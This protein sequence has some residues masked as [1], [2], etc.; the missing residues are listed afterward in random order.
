MKQTIGIRVPDNSIVQAIIES[1]GNPLVSTSIHA[2]DEIQ[3][4]LTEIEEIYEVWQ[5]KVDCIVDGGTGGNIGSTVIDA[6]DEEPYIIR[7]G[8]GMELI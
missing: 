2:E 7:E 8:K 5:D 1:L 6:T 3:T 4:Y